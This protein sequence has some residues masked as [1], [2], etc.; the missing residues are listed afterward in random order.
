VFICDAAWSSWQLL[1]T[2][3]IGA[4]VDDLAL[5]QA[6]LRLSSSGVDL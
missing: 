6:C 1:P 5:M 2:A 3:A 4:E